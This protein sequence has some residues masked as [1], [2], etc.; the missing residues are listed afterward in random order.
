MLLGL[1]GDVARLEDAGLRRDAA[2]RARRLGLLLARRDAARLH[3][4][5][6]AHRLV[7]EVV[8]GL[9]AQL[10]GGLPCRRIEGAELLLLAGGVLPARRSLD[11]PEG[12]SGLRRMPLRAELWRRLL[13]VC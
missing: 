11:E 9:V 2:R 5:P 12:S 1:K 7:Q 8:D 10:L 3:L 13:G 6:L 4:L